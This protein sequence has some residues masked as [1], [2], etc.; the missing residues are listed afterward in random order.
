MLI[1]SSL[2]HPSF[3]FFT[4]GSGGRGVDLFSFRL[5]ANCV[6]WRDMKQNDR[7]AEEATCITFT[8][9]KEG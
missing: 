2:F 3:I 6:S 8:W 5:P 4:C 9:Y 7:I 1:F